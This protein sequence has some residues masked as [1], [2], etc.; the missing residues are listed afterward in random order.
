MMSC[1]EAR[2]LMVLYMGGLLDPLR[3]VQLE[4]H[5]DICADCQ[6]EYEAARL[7]FQLLLELYP[8]MEMDVEGFVAKVEGFL[9]EDAPPQVL[10]AP[11]WLA[12]IAGVALLIGAIASACSLMGVGEVGAAAGMAT[13]SRMGEGV[14]SSA[15]R[16]PRLYPGDEVETGKESTV[17]LEIGRNGMVRVFENTSLG[18]IGARWGLAAD[19]G[20]EMGQIEVVLQPGLQNMTVS[21][22]GGTMRVV[23]PKCRVQVIP[24]GHSPGVCMVRLEVNSGTV[25]W[26]GEWGLDTVT[27]GWGAEAAP[28]ARPTFYRI[29]SFAAD[30]V[31]ESPLQGLPEEAIEGVGTGG[32][33]DDAEAAATEPSGS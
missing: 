15:A 13:V 18:L 22:P 31:T 23:G 30:D 33:S 7:G 16:L 10:T 29:E 28:G 4:G 3:R 25:E 1:T 5:V 9:P 27:M 6:Q 11:R 26:S 19:L 21:T 32:Q 14:A 8:P 17:I 24:N 12:G 20:L 2:N